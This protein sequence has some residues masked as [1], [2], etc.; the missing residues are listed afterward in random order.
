MRPEVGRSSPLAAHQ[1]NER[2]FAR[3][4]GTDEDAGGGDA[5]ADG[6]RD[7]EHD[8]GLE[9]LQAD[10]EV[11]SFRLTKRERGHF[12]PVRTAERAHRPKSKIAQLPVVAH[13]SEDAEEAL[14]ERA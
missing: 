4:I 13:T 12:D 6:H 8:R 11:K 1:A 9:S 10:A 2:R 14:H 3:S 7:Q 5:R